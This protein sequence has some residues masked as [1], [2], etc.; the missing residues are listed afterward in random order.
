VTPFEVGLDLPTRLDG[1]FITNQVVTVVFISDILIQFNLPFPEPTQGDGAY[2]RRH[3]KIAYRYL[4][5][6]FTLDLVTVIPFDILVL[7]GTLS[8]PVKGTKLIRIMRLLKVLKV[9][10]SSAIIERWKSSF[11]VSTSTL[12]MTAYA[13]GAI[14]VLHW[15]SCGWCLLATLADSQR[16]G[17][18]SEA[19]SVL[20]A[21]VLDRIDTL[22]AGGAECN[23]CFDDDETTVAL[24]TSPCLTACERETLAQLEGVSTQFV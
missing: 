15:L 8:G 18:G 4:L 22:T 2:E 13:F 23:A 16:G 17:P 12:Q 24:C 11:A 10:R 6:W 14:V 20:A 19:R 9:L 3:S 5:S 21:A 1:L 7:L